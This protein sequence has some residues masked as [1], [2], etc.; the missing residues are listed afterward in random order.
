[1]GSTFLYTKGRW[2]GWEI[3]RR[4]TD[5]EEQSQ[6]IY[7]FQIPVRDEPLHHVSFMMHFTY[8]SETLSK[9]LPATACFGTIVVHDPCDIEY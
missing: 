6:Y 1:V 2:G 9:Y 4:E 5:P 3:Y 8:E 7:T